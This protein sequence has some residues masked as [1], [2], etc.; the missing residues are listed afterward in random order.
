MARTTIDGM[1]RRRLATMSND[2][3]AEFD[4]TYEATRLALEVGD[5]VLVSGT[6]WCG[7]CHQCL[8]GTP[9]WCKYL[10]P[11]GVPNDPIA[12]MADRVIRFGDGN[13]VDVAVNETRRD[14][15]DL[16]W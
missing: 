12:D 7:Q 15:K 10:A 5:R 9:E 4:E 3:R 8:T 16:S 14:A 6:P 13:I 1:K 11:G 2:E